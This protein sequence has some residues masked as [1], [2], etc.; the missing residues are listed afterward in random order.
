MAGAV[1]SYCAVLIGAR[2]RIRTAID[3]PLARGYRDRPYTRRPRQGSRDPT[4]RGLTES[5]ARPERRATDGPELLAASDEV[6][7]VPVRVFKPGGLERADQVYV[8]FA[9]RVGQL[10]LLEGDSSFRKRRYF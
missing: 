3:D 1:S 5:V 8:S 6:E 9:R 2:C 4:G 10:V 7:D